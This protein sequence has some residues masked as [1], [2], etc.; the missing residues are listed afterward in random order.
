M[1]VDNVL[2]KKCEHLA[3]ALFSRQR[4]QEGKESRT[5]CSTFAGI[6]EDGYLYMFE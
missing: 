4:D 5:K 6:C 1:P 2:S 3:L